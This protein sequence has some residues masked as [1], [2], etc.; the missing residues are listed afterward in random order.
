MLAA[1]TSASSGFLAGCGLARLSDAQG[2]VAALAQLSLSSPHPDISRLSLHALCAALQQPSSIRVDVLR[3]PPV[4]DALRAGA[5]AKDGVCRADAM[6]ALS[7]LALTPC[8]AGVLVSAG[9]VELIVAR[10][11][12]EMPAYANGKRRGL[13]EALSALC[14]LLRHEQLGAG[15]AALQSSAVPVLLAA[16]T[17]AGGRR[18]MVERTLHCLARLTSDE[19]GGR[20]GIASEQGAL[21]S[22]AA[23]L[24]VDDA[25]VVQAAAAAI[26]VSP[27]P[28]TQR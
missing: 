26:T 4:L 23:F 13:E 5:A 25:A 27:R 19:S 8:T 22:L 12:A 2:L 3:T 11:Q 16:L 6:D 21:L 28:C 15:A 1:L 17:T 9:V 24:T 7:A 18:A 10:L 14:S 20:E